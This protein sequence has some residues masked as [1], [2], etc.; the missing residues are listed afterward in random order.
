MMQDVMRVA[1]PGIR[2]CGEKEHDKVD[3]IDIIVSHDCMERNRWRD[4]KLIVFVRDPLECMASWYKLDVLGKEG[5]ED[6][7]PTFRTFALERVVP[8]WICFVQEYLFDSQ[9]DQKAAVFGY[10]SFIEDPNKVLWELG[11]ELN[12]TLDSWTALHKVPVG[13]K[14]DHKL[15]KHYE[16][17][18]LIVELKRAL[19]PY[20]LLLQQRGLI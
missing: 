14:N 6:T 8:Y 11:I 20:P 19:G 16:D 13:L 1:A 17:H 2:M 4:R 18:K 12:Q 3:E 9:V 10:R 7:L 5:R 15:F